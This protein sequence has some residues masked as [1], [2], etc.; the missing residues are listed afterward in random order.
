MVVGMWSR[1][2]TSSMSSKISSSYIYG[3]LDQLKMQQNRDST[4]KMYFAVW[5]Q[6]NQFLI[7]LDKKPKSWEECV[8]LYATYLVDWGFQS[9]SLKSYV[10]VIKSVLRSDGYAWNDDKVSLNII[11]GL[12]S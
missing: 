7:R 2:D 10:S 12:V 4:T 5:R 11:K 8:A 9:S 6:L 3:I 1:A